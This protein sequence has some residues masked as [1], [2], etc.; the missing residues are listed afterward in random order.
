MDISKDEER[1]EEV[2]Q[3]REEIKALK[4]PDCYGTMKHEV[5]SRILSRLEA[6]LARLTQGWKDGAA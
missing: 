2:R 4:H 6:E 5:W 3:L 1:Y